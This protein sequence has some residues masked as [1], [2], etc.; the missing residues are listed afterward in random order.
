MNMKIDLLQEGMADYNF[1]VSSRQYFREQADKECLTISQY[2]RKRALKQMANN[3]GLAYWPALVYGPRIDP[4]AY[5][6]AERI[7]WA[8]TGSLWGEKTPDGMSHGGWDS[9]GYYGLSPWDVAAFWYAAGCRDS[10]KFRLQVATG[11]HAKKKE[12]TNFFRAYARGKRWLAAN[13]IQLVCSRKATAALG[14]LSWYC[15]WAAIHGVA[16]TDHPVRVRELNWAAVKTAQKGIRAAAQFF[17]PALR[18]KILWCQM[19]PDLAELCGGI[20]APSSAFRALPDP[21]GLRIAVV[22]RLILE[23]ETLENLVPAC[24]LVQLFGAD[25]SALRRFVGNRSVHDAG[26]IRLPDRIQPGWGKLILAAPS[27]LQHSPRFAEIEKILGGRVPRSP[28]EAREAI[29]KLPPL[30]SEIAHQIGLSEWEAQDYERFFER[31]RNKELCAVPA[32]GGRTGLR[33]GEY[34]LMQLDSNDPLQVMAGLLTD[35][36]QHLHG[37]ASSCAKAAWRDPRAAIWAVFKD[38]KMV[39]QSFVWRSENDDLVLD[40]VEAKGGFRN[41]DSVAGLFKLAAESVVGRLGI[42]RVLVPAECNYG[43]TRLVADMA[44]ELVPTPTPITAYTDAG[45]RCRVLAENGKPLTL[46]PESVGVCDLSVVAANNEED[47]VNVLMDGSGV[48]CEFCDAEV[49]PDAEVCPVCGNDIS[50]WVDEDEL[51]A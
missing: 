20:K 38:G 50:E 1:I 23:Q 30:V 41:N 22:R 33:R 8:Q 5:L 40:S 6:V 42:Q 19:A 9:D 3:I 21:T 16:P 28:K 39:A 31:S 37:A 47:P 51:A 13:Q 34:T 29:A 11:I 27:L 46:T 45:D 43:L 24:R 32:P 4:K 7:L 25:E 36:C 49:H 44:G 17:P 26:Q 14:R 15:R 35:C 18:K 10:R 2:L 48:F 12:S